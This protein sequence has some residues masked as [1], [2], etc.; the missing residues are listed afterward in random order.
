MQLFPKKNN[1]IQDDMLLMTKIVAQTPISIIVTSLEGMI[2]YSNACAQG[3][4]QR[5][6]EELQGQPFSNFFSETGDAVPW[7]ELLSRISQKGS[8]NARVSMVR[9]DGGDMS[10]VL[11]AF[12]SSTNTTLPEV[13]I[14]VFR[15][16]TKDIQTAEEIEK[17]NVEMA[18]MNSE[19]ILGCEELKRISDLKSNFLSI[20]SHELKTPL[21]SIKGYSDIIIDTMKDKIDLGVYRMIE[22]INR[23]ADRLH[24]VVNNIL[25][26][27]RI[28]QKKLRLKPEHID[29]GALIK[30]CIDELSHF[31]A[32]RKIRFDCQFEESLPQF[33]GDK[34]R[35][36]QV[37]MNLFSNALKFSPDNSVIEIKLAQGG[38]DQFHVIVKDH[39]IGIEKQEQRKI[40]DPFYE[41]GDA[42]RHTSSDLSKFMGGGTGLGLSI[43]K[44]VI[45]RHGGR[46]WVESDPEQ[47]KEK[48]PGSE[49][50][51]ILPFEAKIEW[52]DDET[53]GLD[54]KKLSALEGAAI[55]ADA[56]NVEIKPSILF[57]DSDR[58]AVEIARMVLE[59]AFEIHVAETGEIGLLMAFNKTP[60]IILL[61]SYLPGLDGYRVCKLLRSQEETKNTPIAFFSAGTQSSE[62]QK[63]FASGADDF[64]VK[65][66][67]GKEIVNKIWR[68]LMKQKEKRNFK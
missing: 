15:D 60:S 30:E 21:T 12:Q 46:I 29:L 3:V 23:A 59:N 40:F 13:M 27:T 56:E 44:G 19:L 42:N 62:I 32:N 2:H 61:D 22:S 55:S 66:F 48:F 45:E 67:N 16:L 4:L 65:P 33:L 34:M 17:K 51:I 39:G 5:S 49:F 26:V 52:D 63:C 14:W 10:C 6:R 53:K 20:A 1:R 68:L 41:V 57:I 43:V 24:R 28:E 18:K 38:R 58:E 9:S 64:I 11:D 47:S 37:F 31:A 54:L 7:K 8:C 25:D 50:H 36:Q 35:M